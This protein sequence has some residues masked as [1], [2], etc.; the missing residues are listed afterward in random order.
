MKQSLMIM[1]LL[2][3]LST[4]A[5]TLAMVE[6]SSVTLTPTNAADHGFSVTVHTGPISMLT[7]QGNS[8]VVTCIVYSLVVESELQDL[9]QFI[10][11]MAYSPSEKPDVF[12]HSYIPS[13]PDAEPGKVSFA[14][15]ISPAA[16][17]GIR[18]VLRNRDARETVYRINLKDWRQTH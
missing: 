2:T 13:M 4:S 7:Q 12:I 1:L 5:S 9:T 18:I 11:T 16:R 14:F 10:P 3:M 6:T 17:A 8:N 15:T